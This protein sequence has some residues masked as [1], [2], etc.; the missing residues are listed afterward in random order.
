MN[1]M[2]VRD[3]DPPC[4]EKSVCNLQS[5][6]HR[7]GSSSTH[8][9]C[10]AHPLHLAQKLITHFQYV[11]LSKGR[12]YILFILNLPSAWHTAGVQKYFAELISKMSNGNA[13]RTTQRLP[14]CTSFPGLTLMSHRFAPLSISASWMG[15]VI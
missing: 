1:N 13:L 4:S 3:T 15:L 2:G 14:H 6:L 10:L 12:N 8:S 9:L 7:C 5:A 11:G